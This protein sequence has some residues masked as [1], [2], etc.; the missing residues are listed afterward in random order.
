M[1]GR[2]A[3][4]TEGLL[5]KVRRFR[6]IIKFNGGFKKSMGILYRTDELKIGELVGEDKYGNKYYRND[7]YFMARNKWVVF[8]K[9]IGVNYN[10]SQ[11]PPEWHRWMTD[12]T[13][14]PPSV[15]PLTEHKWMGE[16]RENFTGTKKQYVPYSTTQPKIQSWQPKNT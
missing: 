2:A 16:Y 7:E 14:T 11:I 6:D 12:M 4:P 8:N 5:A 3:A 9:N 1:A 10:A 15:Q 13:D